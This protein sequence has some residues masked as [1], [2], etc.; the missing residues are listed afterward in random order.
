MTRAGLF[1][2]CLLVP[3]LAPLLALAEGDGRERIGAERQVVELRFAAE[4]R[5]CRERFAVTACL[6]DSRARRRAA[7]APLR[8]RELRLDDAERRAR[9]DER[10]AAVAA[11]QAAAASRPAGGSSARPAK[12]P[13][14]APAAAER[15]SRPRDTGA[16]QA[17]QASEAAQRAQAAQRRRDAARQTQERVA[18]RLAE[19]AATGKPA[20][21]LPVP[22]PAASAGR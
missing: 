1:A 13:A 16:A 18:R 15:A 10:R 7:L 8:E 4:Q 11:K 14:I 21:P 6:D 22:G 5:D 2:M 12:V 19:K 20:E 3:M 17:G 9:G